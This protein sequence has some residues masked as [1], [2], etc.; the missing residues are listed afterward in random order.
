MRIVKEVMEE[1]EVTCLWTVGYAMCA[2]WRNLKISK[3]HNDMKSHAVGS[4]AILM[5]T[6]RR[7]ATSIQRLVRESK[8]HIHS[9]LNLPPQQ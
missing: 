2:R 3:R 8:K 1:A 9:L 7:K 6:I 4:I 5:V